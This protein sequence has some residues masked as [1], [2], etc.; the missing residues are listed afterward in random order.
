MKTSNTAQNDMEKEKLESLIAEAVMLDEAFMA[1]LYDSVDVR[2]MT[3][4]RVPDAIQ[5]EIFD[6]VAVGF[7]AVTQAAWG[8]DTSPAQRTM[9]RAL[10]ELVEYFF[11]QLDWASIAEGVAASIVDDIQYNRAWRETE[12]SMMGAI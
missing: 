11:D 2:G 1:R 3:A 5:L 7:G 8:A 4:S 10:D 9:I 12:R 6:Y